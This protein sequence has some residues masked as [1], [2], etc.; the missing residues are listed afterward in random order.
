MGPGPGAM[1]VHPVYAS[2]Q[3]P[4]YTRASER[5]ARMLGRAGCVRRDEVLG[6]R[7]VLRHGRS[8]SVGPGPA[9]V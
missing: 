9:K 2:L 3:H 4:G 7:L 6:S 5:V 8:A 1:C